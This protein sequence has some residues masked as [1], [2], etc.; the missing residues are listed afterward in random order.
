MARAKGYRKL[1]RNRRW[2]S[3]LLAAL[4]FVVLSLGGAAPARCAETFLHFPPTSFDILSPE[5][6][7]VIG[8]GKYIVEPI[9]AGAV[10]KGE[11][12]YLN[13]DYDVE[14]DR[15]AITTDS[16][17]PALVSF[18]HTFYGKDGSVER[19]GRADI[20]TGTGWCEATEDGRRKIENDKFDFPSDTYA[21]ASVLIPI[22]NY[23]KN[24]ETSA[25]LHMH[26][27]NCI[28]GPK[29]L[30]IQAGCGGDSRRFPYPGALVPVKVTP[31]FGFWN[32]FLSPFIPKITAWFDPGTGWDFVGG[33]LDRY[34]RG[35]KVTL[36]KTH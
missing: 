34:Y 8:H 29:L 13:G 28:P 16:P 5:T 27:F 15:M 30:E 2:A 9:T 4:A 25:P 35:P 11:S 7:Q 31:D 6:G 1:L 23:L 21:G 10:L 33:S 36:V 3:G 22:Q 12:H 18:R 32:A 14:E 26:V 20:R 17:V 19:E 24:G